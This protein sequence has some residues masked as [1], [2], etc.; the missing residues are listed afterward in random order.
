MRQLTCLMILLLAVSIA[1]SYKILDDHDKHHEESFKKGGG[2]KFQEEH[3]SEQG[4]KGEKGYEKKKVAEKGEKGHHDKERHQKNYK[5]EGGAKKSHHADAGYYEEKHAGEKGEKGF[6]FKDHGK[7]AKGHDTK[8]EHNVRKLNEFKKRTDFFDED[9]DQAFKENH[10][11]YEHEKGYKKGGSAKASKEAGGFQKGGYGKS[12]KQ[13]KGG[14][15]HADKGYKKGGG[16]ESFYD[17]GASYGEE[18]KKDGFKKYD[19]S[20]KGY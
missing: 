20:K 18:G 5:E 9:H 10:G 6:S 8:G 15:H 2:K 4:E 17:K 3:Q 12:K 11:E 14:H 13:E 7:Y 19:F 1:M 16:R